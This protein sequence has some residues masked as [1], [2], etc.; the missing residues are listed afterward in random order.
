MVQWLRLCA[1][2]V[3]IRVQS[4]V[5][6][7][8][9]TCHILKIPHTTTKTWYSPNTVLK[10]KKIFLMQKKKKCWHYIHIFKIQSLPFFL[11]LPAV[12]QLEPQLATIQKPLNF[13]Q[14][15]MPFA[16][17]PSMHQGLPSPRVSLK[18][19]R[20]HAEVRKAH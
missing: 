20:D 10:I 2:D 14:H 5:R 13:L 6:E 15:L 7:L 1:P 19:T 3:G 17:V 4:L 11:S 18:P 16:F 8:D 12:S 9:P